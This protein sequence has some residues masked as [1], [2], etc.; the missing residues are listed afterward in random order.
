MPSPSSILVVSSNPLMCTVVPALIERQAALVHRANVPSLEAALDF[1]AHDVP[2]LVI[3]D[4]PP[5]DARQVI[6]WRTLYECGPRLLMLT[7][8]LDQRADLLSILA[9]ACGLVLVP[10][11]RLVDSLH[12]ALRGELIRSPDLSGY[13]RSLVTGEAP[14]PL[15]G[16][17]RRIL[18][19]VSDGLHD[20]EI[21]HQLRITRDAVQDRI[22]LIAA[23]LA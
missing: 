22:A 8:Y 13:L 11:G 20:S 2:D 17:E 5:C 3:S 10:E 12:R 21:A 23:K 7:R 14:S 15:D 4:N 9:G 16:D 6:A 1:V 19:F 18:G